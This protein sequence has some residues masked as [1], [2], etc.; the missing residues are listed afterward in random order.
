MIVLVAV[1][2]VVQVIVMFVVVIVVMVVVVH[3]RHQRGWVVVV[4]R[5]HP[6]VLQAYHDNDEPQCAAGDRHHCR[7]CMHAAAGGGMW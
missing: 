2:V 6:T 1:V 5:G 4:V 7:A 3:C